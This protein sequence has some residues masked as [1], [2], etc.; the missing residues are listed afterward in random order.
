ME[1]ITNDLLQR[2][3]KQKE[4]HDQQMSAVRDLMMQD[5]DEYVK[6]IQDLKVNDRLH[7]LTHF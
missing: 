7:D 4:E 1:E 2:I 6:S 5:H 3:E